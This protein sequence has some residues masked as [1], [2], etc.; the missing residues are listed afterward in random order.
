[1]NFNAVVVLYNPD[2]AVIDN[3]KTYID[4]VD[5][6][7]IYDN[8]E[9]PSFRQLVDV[10]LPVG[11]VKYI[12]LN[13][14]KGIAFPINCAIQDCLNNKVE[15][16]L[17]MDQDSSFVDVESMKSY[18]IN[19]P[20]FYSV[21][22]YSPFHN[23]GTRDIP[24]QDV[25]LVKSVMTSGNFINV[26]LINSIGNLREDFFIDCI[27]HEL[28]A[29]VINH[30][31]L[32]KQVNFCVLHHGLG[33]SIKKFLGYEI[34]NHSPLRRYYITRNSLYLI[35]AFMFKKTR[36][37]LGYLKSF[38]MNTLVSL[39]FEPDKTKKIKYITKGVIHYLTRKS[40][41]YS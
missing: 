6:L 19:D 28:C 23:T 11:K 38:V 18:I 13:G 5:F 22:I 29:Q 24:S 10:S 3:I 14:N 12:F 27:D 34:T 30:G 36:F 15:C 25:S 32:I 1:M 33:S 31:L 39:A 9:D 17:T 41:K 16:L 8:S 4:S 21:G 26:K 40:G 35:E 7:F 2:A 20:E 37:S